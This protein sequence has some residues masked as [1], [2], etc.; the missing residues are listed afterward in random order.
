MNDKTPKKGDAPDCPCFADPFA[1]T[2]GNWDDNESAC[3]CAD[4]GYTADANQPLPP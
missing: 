2:C 1:S 4:L 3:V